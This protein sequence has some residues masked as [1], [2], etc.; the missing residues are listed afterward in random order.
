MCPDWTVQ[1]VV[2]HLTGLNADVASGRTDNLG[3]DEST[4]RQVSER[5]G[6]SLGEICDEWEG[7][8]DEMASQMQA[9]PKLA[10]GLT[11][12]LIVHI[13]DVQH[14]L[15]ME[16]DRESQATVLAAHRYV[17]HMQ[18]RVQEQLGLGLSVSLTDGSEWPVSGDPAA[19]LRTTPYDFLRSVTGRRSRRQ[20]E[21]LEWGGD[22]AVILDNAW[23]TYGPLQE[24]DVSA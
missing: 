21:A 20:V 8:A 16:I 22:V 9:R 11:A 5:R 3:S 13:H 12:D 14:A 23:T 17:P 15:G 6:K 1:D 24:E 7:H 10:I 4:N 19:T 2:A 18:D